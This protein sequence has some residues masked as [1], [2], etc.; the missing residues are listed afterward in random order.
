[1][2]QKT[3]KKYSCFKNDEEVLILSGIFRKIIMF[4]KTNKTFMIW[5]FL[6]A[7]LYF[8]INIGAVN[9]CYNIYLNDTFVGKVKK[10][11]SFNNALTSAFEESSRKAEKNIKI[12]PAFSFGNSALTEIE[13]K[14]QI[15]KNCRGF[16]KR[17]EPEPIIVEPEKEEDNS[18]AVPV[19]ADVSSQFGERWGR[20]HKGVD[21]AANYGDDI[22]SAKDGV[23]KFCGFEQTF[24]NLIIIEH[25]DGFESYYGHMSRFT[26]SLGDT[27][28]KGQK[29]GEV[30]N[31][32]NSTG[33]HLHFEIRHNGEAVNPAQFISF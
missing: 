11:D 22:L 24:G 20:L 28:S 9:F 2:K 1:M 30:G 33:P 19:F 32:G 10:I 7:F 4:L 14:E 29:I 21:F 26:V 27:V 12:Y 17:V 23:I 5:G 31:T 8:L 18:F 3:L 15:V 16:E 13:I 6:A 25:E